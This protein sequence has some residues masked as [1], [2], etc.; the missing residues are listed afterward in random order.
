MFLSIED[1][2]VYR[3]VLKK[4]N[5]NYVFLVSNDSAMGCYYVCFYISLGKV[6]NFSPSHAFQ[7]TNTD[8]G[9]IA[10]AIYSGYY[11]FGGW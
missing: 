5:R 10:L 7:N 2:N 8:I 3:P 4:L 9:S 11:A 6:E 1:G